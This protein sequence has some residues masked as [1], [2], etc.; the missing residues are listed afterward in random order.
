M[1]N[2]KKRS[3]AKK[4][5]LN[6]KILI[7]VVTALVLGLAVTTFFIS[8][9]SA[10]ITRD[11]S[12][13][14]GKQIA[15]TVASDVQ[16]DLNVAM[17]VTETMRDAF[18]GL[19][20]AG[21]KDRATYLAMLE[22]AVKANPQFVGVWTAWEPNAF[23]GKDVEYVNADGKATFPNAD[24]HDA[25]GRF[26]PYVFTTTPGSFGHAP[27]LDYT[28][29]GPGDY[30][31]LAQKSGKQ[32]I[33]EPYSYDVDGKTVI[34]TSLVTPIVIDGKVLG[35]VGLD[36]DLAAIQ[37]R[38]AKVKP[39]ETGSV[40]LISN[41]G[42]F[43]AYEDPKFVMKP[44]NEQ[45]ESLGRAKEAVA[46]GQK[47]EFS[48]FSKSL[49]VNILRA[50][51]PVEIGTTG[52]PWSVMVNLPEDKIL[53]PV[54]SLTISTVVAALVLVLALSAIVAFLIRSLV[55]RPVGGLTQAVQTLADGNTAITVPATTRGD[56][57]GVMARAVE[58]FRQKLIEIDEL[59]AKTAAAEQESAAARRKGMLELADSFES[60]VKGVVEAVSAS[61]V[62]LEASAKSMSSVA[63]E[64]TRQS[65]AVSAAT[66]EASANVSTVAAASEEMSASIAEIS[67]Q[68][69]ASSGA[70]RSAVGET[71]SAA[72]T[73]QE[74]A[75][76]AEEIGDIVR[77]IS[78]IAGQTNLLA[79]NA[80]IEAARAGDAGK[81]FAVVASEVK[82]LA[83]QTGR[84]AEDITSRIQRIQSVTGDAVKAMD[85]VR[86]TI[87]KVEEIATTIASAVE[88]QSAATREISGNAGQAAA[89][90]D[91]VARNV[92]RVKNAAGDA[93]SA[94]G[95]VREASG[96]LAQQSEALRREVD[97]FIA[98][99]RA[100]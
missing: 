14:N 5:S 38:L 30:Y 73:V 83:T 25:T 95:Q 2:Q 7:S 49:Q 44:I 79:L 39:Y 18:I 28:K 74:L 63:E 52:T 87:S 50:F 43:A 11:L 67:R 97:S 56:E 61:A 9:R 37:E 100:G 86:S 48:D 17:R 72:N 70:A 85:G 88:E 10:G 58:F 47:L 90:T 91:E 69:A 3:F 81:G 80:T 33:I 98:R 21:N 8:D 77:L 16:R 68:V 64:V 55:V 4:L 24:L 26:I 76:A 1:S 23:D 75:K 89:G 12:E 32:Q 54:K 82:S 84:A 22:S 34:M 78:D 51:V 6:A 66:T 57:L 19:Y 92:E 62:E 65:T 46:K 20:G 27:L 41:A 45:N 13:Q 94:A 15:T 60:S 96:E 35:V 40:S 36:L 53:A 59:R 93:G 31:L 42:N 99:V 29:P 71:D